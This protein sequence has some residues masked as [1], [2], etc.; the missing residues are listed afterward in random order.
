VTS[1]RPK[2]KNV[3][4]LA[5]V[6]ATFSEPMDR[7]TVTTATFQLFR[8]SSTAAIPAS[9]TYSATNNRATLDPNAKLRRGVTYRAVVAAEAADL[10]GNEMGTAKVWHFKTKRR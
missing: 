8:R 2:G 4:R 10:A 5:N 9:L 3:S 7:G 6:K 1:T